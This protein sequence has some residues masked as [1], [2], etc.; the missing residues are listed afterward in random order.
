MIILFNTYICF[1]SG[2][3]ILRV[4]DYVSWEWTNVFWIYWV[5]FV[6][7]VAVNLAIILLFFG[8]MSNKN[9]D[10]EDEVQA[11]EECK[12]LFILKIIKN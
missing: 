2:A 12:F 5:F 6:V 10:Q 7:L 3:M 9:E 8:K 1:Q 4:F 11:K